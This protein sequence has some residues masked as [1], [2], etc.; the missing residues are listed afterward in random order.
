MEIILAA[1]EPRLADAFALHTEAMESVTVTAGSILDVD[2][3]AIVSPANSFGFMDGGIDAVYVDHFGPVVQDRVRRRILMDYDGELLVGQAA[4]VETD[5]DAIPF[6]I[7]APTMRVPM[8]LGA[9]TVNPYLATR[10]ALSLALRGTSSDGQRIL[11]RVHR[12]AFPG[13]GTGVGG[14]PA[15][16]AARQMAA[17]IRTVRARP[18]RLPRSW[19]EASEDHQRLY[20]HKPIRLQS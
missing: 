4:I 17:A 7:A 5:D 9:E 2:C 13:M 11:D 8:W 18:I 20:T 3:D 1:P 12:I 6:L 19:A 15:D 14:V 16:I 10:A